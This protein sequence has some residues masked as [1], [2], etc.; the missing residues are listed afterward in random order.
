[1]QFLLELKTTSEDCSP[2]SM[3]WKKLTLDNQVSMYL[4]AAREMGFDVMG[5][6]Y[7]VIRKTALRPTSKG[8]ETPASYESRIIGQMIEAPDRYFTRGVIVRTEADLEAH[9]DDVWQ[10]AEL[11]RHARN[12]DRWPRYIGACVS[13]GSTCDY[14]PVCAEGAEIEGAHYETRPPMEAAP[15]TPEGRKHLPV[16]SASALST[17]RQC[18][19][20]FYYAYE[21]RRRKVGET[22]KP[23]WFGKL[24]HAAIETYHLEGIDAALE[25]ASD[26]ERTPNEHDRAHARALVRG[27]DA[28]WGSEPLRIIATEKPFTRALTNPET[29]A[30]SRTFQ[31]GGVVD[32]VVEEMGK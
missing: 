11:I 28:R 4:A 3:Y 14:W 16:L 18:P 30:A 29:G 26:S 2:G 1:M 6:V 27:Y 21:L 12:K 22:S 19:R 17:W 7:D 23:L 15:G 24:I 10:I 32:A 20:K 5:V 13:Y 31:L 9:A 25:R 8:T